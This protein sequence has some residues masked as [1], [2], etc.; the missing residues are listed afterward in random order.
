M[1]KRFFTCVKQGQYNQEYNTQLSQ[2]EQ[3]QHTIINGHR[4][5]AMKMSDGKYH[6]CNSVNYY[7][8]I[9]WHWDSR[10]NAVMVTNVDLKLTPGTTDINLGGYWDAL[11]FVNPNYPVHEQAGTFTPP[12]G[13]LPGVNGEAV[14][15]EIGNK[16]GVQG[17]YTGNNNTHETLVRYSKNNSVPYKAVSLGNGKYD[18]LDMFIRANDGASNP[19]RHSS[20]DPINVMWSTLNTPVTVNLPVLKTQ[21]L[22]YHYDETSVNFLVQ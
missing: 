21:V 2:L 14:W 13:D 15:N 19:N 5:W 8:D 4:N 18:L 12:A 20:S 1:R 16:P 22:H 9:T 11:G 6:N 17:L 10:E 7:V 3:D